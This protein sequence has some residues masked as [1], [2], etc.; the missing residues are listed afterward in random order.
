MNIQR[1]SLLDGATGAR[2]CTVIIDVFR[3]FTCASVIL[4]F[5]PTE[6]RLEQDAALC[7]RLKREEGYLAVGEID[8]V[9][10]EGFDLGNSPSRI[11]EADPSLFAGRKVVLRTSAG[12]RGVFAA[13][14]EANSVWAGSYTTA[15]ALAR[16]IARENPPEVS[17]VA[18]GWNA[19]VKS[20]EDEHCAALLHSLLDPRVRYDHTRA[21]VE[22][23]ADESARKFL[24]AD[25]EHFPP[26]DVTWCL[27]RDLYEFAMKVEKCGG[28]LKLVKST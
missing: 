26:A 27:Q 21:L 11:A 8:G 10:V 7:L 24:R 13:R 2:G 22:I 17:I 28:I 5:A 25:R 15:G 1:K 20:P 3:A 19:E 14:K 9:T 4:D 16:A 12:V 6:L 18:M 23:M